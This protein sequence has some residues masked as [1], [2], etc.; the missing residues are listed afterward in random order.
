MEAKKRLDKLLKEKEYQKALTEMTQL[1]APVD[2]FFDKVL[3][4]DKDRKLKDNRLALLGQA[5]DLFSSIADFS[6]IVTE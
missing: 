4:M 3:V 2:R 1:K 6:K 5:A